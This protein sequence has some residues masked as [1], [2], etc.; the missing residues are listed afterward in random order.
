MRRLVLLLSLVAL[1]ACRDQA[2]GGG[3]GARD[4]ISAVGSST[5]YPF[6]TAV[7]ESFMRA[8]P[9]TRV[10]VESTGTGAGIKLFCSGV[11]VSTIDVANA[12]RRM[13]DGEYKDCQK[14][15]VKEIVEVKIG[16]EY[17]G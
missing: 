2:N 3:A 8:N 7:A 11:G 4:Q 9:G 14:N 13:K 17:E 1:S 15:G 16:F 10:I 12:S 5:V 6:T